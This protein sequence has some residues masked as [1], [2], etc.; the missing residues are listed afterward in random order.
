MG[1]VFRSLMAGAGVFALV[2]VVPV[3]A[4]LAQE[5]PVIT[6]TETVNVTL[7]A[8]GG[9]EVARVYDQIAIQGS[10]EVSY[11]NPV[12]T[13]GL[14]N[15][16]GFAGFTVEDG[17]IVEDTSVSSQVRRRTVSDFDLDLPVTVAITY[18]LDGE[19][20][21]PADVVGKSGELEVTYRVENMTGETEEIDV[22]NPQ[23][24]T[25]T[26]EEKVYDPIAGSLT[27]TLPPNFTDVTS[28]SGAVIAGDGRGGTKLSFSVTLIPPLGDPV[29]EVS[30]TAAVQD[31]VVPEANLTVVP[32]VV[33]ANPTVSGAKESFEGGAE[34]GRE[35]TAGA[36]E[37]DA[38]VLK[39]ADG[40]SD[41]VEG[42]ILLRDGSGELSAGLAGEAAPG[43]NEL[44]DGA[45]QLSDGLNELQSQV[46][47]L[48][49]GV[50]QLDQGGNQLEAGLQQLQ[51]NLPALNAGVDQLVDGAKQLEAGLLQLQSQIPALKAGVA[52]LLAGA[53]QLSKGLNDLEAGLDAKFGPGL[54][55]LATDLATAAGQGGLAD[56]LLFVTG[57]TKAGVCAA[58]GHNDPAA[59]AAGFATLE[60]AIDKTARQAVQDAADGAGLLNGAYAAPLSNNPPGIRATIGAL[61]TG[62]DQLAGGLTQLNDQI[63][64]LESGVNALVAGATKLRTGL[65]QLK[66]S[67]GPL[68]SGVA[69]L[70]AGATQ[71]SDGLSELRSKVSPLS[72][73]VNQLADGGGQLAAGAGELADGL[74]DAADGSVQLAAGL[75]DAAEAAPALPEGATRLSEEGTSQLV[76]AGEDTAETFAGQVATLE[77][78]AERTADGGLPYG[79]PED[80][81][82][83]AAYSYDINGASG[84]TSQ[85][86]GR[87]IAGLAIGG[88]AAVGAGLM[89][90]R[91]KAA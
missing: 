52:S 81:L 65:E 1:R 72:D 69:E 2:L 28:E 32:V 21:A 73:G 30:Y 42:L 4:A 44:A 3:T 87:L 79:A 35:L 78:G 22:V 29:A 66:A 10:G 88:G 39:L 75:E 64:A 51:A 24:E 11:K 5:E 59:C 40:A 62:A 49:A 57:Q 84:T 82:R 38:N 85:N 45:S 60:G 20:I 36:T 46:P 86:A 58:P 56:Q 80:A 41:L 31:A 19:E 7:D 54:Q 12:S 89:A 53:Q 48:I 67:A 6:N 17:A 71:L 26:I 63:P 34:T 13:S 33:D 23:G 18:T 14:R 55:K 43:A 76:K 25:E 27:M 90:A 91:R 74:G 50:I 47:A 61:S 68:S 15:L 8:T 37:I 77:A 16:D 9:L 70:A 83:F